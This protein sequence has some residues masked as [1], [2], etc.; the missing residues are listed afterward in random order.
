[1]EV[2][3]YIDFHNSSTSTS[4]FDVRLDCRT[5][6]LLRLTG[7][8]QVMSDL[9][10]NA[11]GIGTDD[12][13]HALEVYGSSSNI[14]ITNTA[15]TDAG[16]IFRDSG[17]LATQAAA[18]KF[19]S[20]DQKL[21]FFVNDEVAQRMVIDTN[22]Y[23]G[24]NTAN[25]NVPLDVEVSDTNSSFNDGAAQFSNI[26]TATSGGAT[27][28]N[29]RNNYGGGNGTLIKFFRTSVVTSIG[30]ISF[31]GSGNAVV[32]STTSDYRLKEDLKSFNGLEIIDQIKTYNYKWKKDDS[33]GYGT[34]AHELQE[35][36]PDAV[37]GEK[38]A[39]D[40]QGV[41]YSTLV[42]VL[43][44]SIQELKKELEELKKQL[45]A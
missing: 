10:A 39:E 19:N 42:P 44:K 11:V 21:K 41:D 45:N 38:D 4:D 30:F 43:I 7:N 5:G 16:I 22:G 14:A 18:I 1:M 33:R 25:P 29:V 13:L 26:T 32:Y 36:F 8:F 9:I 27:V 40:M 23:V 31:N 17:G 3:R 20:S 28:I 2:G 35:V 15:E 12:P 24:I 34:L 37:T 6:N